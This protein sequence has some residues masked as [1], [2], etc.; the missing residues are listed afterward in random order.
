MINIMKIIQDARNAE[1]G[2]DT[3]RHKQ[4]TC[5]QDVAEFMGR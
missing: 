1:L 3:T 2:M 5:V 4:I